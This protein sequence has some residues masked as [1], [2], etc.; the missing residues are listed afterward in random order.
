MAG[1]LT[2]CQWPVSR[3][4]EALEAI[5]SRHGL[6]TV[7]DSVPPAPAC[8]DEAEL[9][10][11]IEAF[12]EWL[13][14]EVQAATLPYA[15][16]VESLQSAGPALLHIRAEGESRLLVLLGRTSRSL[17]L[18]G[19]DLRAHRVP[20]EAVASVL[21]EDIEKPAAQRIERV[22]ELSGVKQ[23]RRA[24]VA[25]AILRDRL[26]SRQIGGCWLLRLPPGASFWQQLRQV[27]VP[28]RCAAL[29]AANFGQDLL[30]IAAWWVLGAGALQGR[31][32]RGLL[33]AWLL[34]LGAMLPCRVIATWLQ[35]RVAIG[36][37]GV[38]KQRLL[39][40]ALRLD[41]DEIRSQGAGQ[42]LGRVLES[43][44]VE[45]LA[46]SGGFLALVAAIELLLATAVLAASGIW[47][48]PLLLAAWAGAVIWM[49]RRYF[50]ETDRWTGARL[51]MTH[52]L[53]ERMVGHRTRLAQERRED[54]HAGED[55]SLD[56][57]LHL[58]QG[59]D[60]T[61]ARLQAAGPRGWLIIAVAALGPAFVSGSRSAAELGIAIG[62]ILLAFRAFKRMSG[63][64]WQL[65]GAAIAWKRT[66]VLFHAAARPRRAGA[67][68]YSGDGTSDGAVLDAHDITF[69]YQ[70]RREPVLRG[71]SMRIE[72][73]DRVLLEGPSGGG[74]STLASVICGLR[75]PDSG[76]LL[77]NGLDRHT[78]GDNGWRRGVV[79]APQ[80]HENH[81]LTGT[82]A[83]N[84]MMGCRWPPTPDDF[85][86][87]ESLCDE[88][89]LRP[90][91]ERMPAGLLQC[92]GDTGWQLSHG[93]RSRLYIARALMQKADL[94]VLD[95]SFAA[96]DPENLR[97]A[98]DCVVSRAPSLLVIAHP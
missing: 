54:W 13:G 39:A 24:R 81:V 47:T 77:L 27:R 84:M 55:Q 49:A 90:L 60:R 4:G 14:V 23:R 7:S 65:A 82:F 91:L 3:L 69:R 17:L 45:S 11:A 28:A 37:G 18:L 95:E 57:Y 35:G 62:G 68:G 59:V 51:G 40:G 43:Q 76:L 21:I 34:L 53:V 29:S 79:S 86:E 42:L 31:I 75:A 73:G 12:G 26:A 10:N 38:L 88:L 89:G 67:P 22:L 25:K 97:R 19:T 70:N 92:V 87:M 74:K 2:Q 50:A 36:A 48:E 98:V 32:D 64:L 78:L 6:A 5:A 44:A 52:E 83:F 85:E 15:A 1:A 56:R 72:R 93:E 96:L 61:A 46:L 8:I 33:L 80:F 58:S 9:G 94:V 71:S 16:L 66:A 30:W 63:G 20:S 41:P